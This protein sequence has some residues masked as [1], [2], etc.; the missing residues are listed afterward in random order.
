M[1][2]RLIMLV[3]MVGLVGF[4][5][6]CEDR[7]VDRVGETT[8]EPDA[9]PA[10]EREVPPADT[11]PPPPAPTDTTTMPPADTTTPPPTTGP[12]DTG[13]GAGTPR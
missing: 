10:G 1:V 11:T 3:M 7:D 12:A 9:V 8:M 13:T 5:A 2:S 4:W 6:G